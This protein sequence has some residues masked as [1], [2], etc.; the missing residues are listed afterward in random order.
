[1]RNKISWTDCWYSLMCWYRRT[2]LWR[3]WYAVSCRLWKRYSTV[4]PYRLKDGQWIDRSAL[5]V[6]VMFQVL[7]DFVEKECVPSNPAGKGFGKDP[8]REHCYDD[9]EYRYWMKRAGEERELLELYRWWKEDFEEVQFYATEEQQK[10]IDE[11]TAQRIDLEI[12]HNNDIKDKMKRLVDLSD[13]M[14]T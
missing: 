14:W 9:E 12:A 1:M 3:V 11:G 5:I 13:M 8:K 7:V 6:Y 2:W 4:T 10:Q